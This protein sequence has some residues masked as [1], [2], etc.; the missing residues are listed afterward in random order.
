MFRSRVW[1]AHT[2]DFTKSARAAPRSCVSHRMP[3]QISSS[4]VLDGNL[5]CSDCL[6]ILRDVDGV[7]LGLGSCREG[8][9]G[10]WSR[11]GSVPARRA[12]GLVPG[13]D[14]KAVNAAWR[15][16]ALGLGYFGQTLSV[17]CRLYGVFCSRVD[18][19][20]CSWEIRFLLSKNPSWSVLLQHLT[21]EV[22]QLAGK[23]PKNLSDQQSH[24][25]STLSPLPRQKRA[26]QYC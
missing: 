12:K 14:R 16:P 8:Q 26:A 24:T 19:P 11:L 17:S 5:K 6:V 9:I 25:T 23:L 1:S 21:A 15:D 20:S 3:A 22:E 7:G 2:L 10:F 13:E 18:D 4:R